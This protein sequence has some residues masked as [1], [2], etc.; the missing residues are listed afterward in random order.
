MDLLDLPPELLSRIIEITAWV[1]PR[2]YENLMLTCKTV[3]A[4]GARTLASHNSRKKVWE[5]ITFTDPD[6]WKSIDASRQYAEEPALAEYTEAADFRITGSWGAEEE[7]DEPYEMADPILPHELKSLEDLILRS[8]DLPDH[9]RSPTFWSEYHRLFI[10]AAGDSTEGLDRLWDWSLILLISQLRYISELTLPVSWPSRHY[11]HNVEPDP[12]I[13]HDKICFEATERLMRDTHSSESDAPLKHCKILRFLGPVYQRMRLT[14]VSPFL[15][16]KNVEELYAIG[17]TAEDL[18]DY[19]SLLYQWPYPEL[20]SPLQRLELLGCNIDAKSMANLLAHTPH[21]R[22]L[23]YGHVAHTM[24]TYGR[25]QDFQSMELTQHRG[26]GTSWDAAAFVASIAKQC[27]HQLIELAI[28]MAEVRMPTET[29]KISSPITSMKEFACLEHAEFEVAIFE[30]HSTEIEPT[31][32]RRRSAN[33]PKLVEILPAS[34]KTLKLFD[35]YTRGNGVVE[36]LMKD[37]A[38]GRTWL[39]SDLEDVSYRHRTYRMGGYPADNFSIVEGRV[40]LEGIPWS[41]GHGLNPAWER[42]FGKNHG[43]YQPL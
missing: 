34:L 25:Q 11:A 43:A 19:P 9:I 31:K 20:A 6:P 16:L 42:E 10:R 33:V 40:G 35:G 8:S 37:F 15:A 3:H 30:D 12:N 7:Y 1:A 14:T 17:L 13:K 18:D 21:L 36:A 27:G 4:H 41:S 2:G 26:R 29:I 39:L 5:K 32:V 28:T 22:A 24:S 23:R 38:A